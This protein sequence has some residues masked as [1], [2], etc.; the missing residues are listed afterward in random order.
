MNDRIESNFDFKN[1]DYLSIF[2]SR[3]ERLI[4]IRQNSD[5]LQSLKIYYKFNPAQFIIDWGCTADFAS[6]NK[7]QPA[8]IPFILFDKQNE[9]CNW[10]N[11]LW[12]NNQNGLV[13]KTRQMGMSWLSVALA[14]T[15]C[16]FNDDVK[17]GFGS[18]KEEY[19]DKRGDS[20]S[21]FEKAKIFIELIPKEF[22]GG[23][24]DRLH[25]KS[26]QIKFPNTNST[27]IGESGDNIGRGD[28]TSIYFVDEAAFLER[29]Y[30]AEASLAQGTRCRIDISTPNG[31]ANSFYEKRV[32]GKVPVFTFHWRDDPRKNDDWYNDQ[33]AKLDPVIVAQEIDINYN[34][35]VTGIVIPSLWIQSAIDAHKKLGIDISGMK[36][37]AL[38]VA[39]E[40]KDL[41]TFCGRYGILIQD[42]YEWSGKDS[43]IMYTT[44]QCIGHMDNNKYQQLIYDADGIGAGIRA[45]MRV[46]NESRYGY[47]QIDYTAFHGGSSVIQPTQMITD[48]FNNK[49]YFS[50]YKAQ[51]WWYLRLRFEKTH[52]AVYNNAEYDIDDIISI[53]SELLLLNKLVNELSSPTWSRNSSG[54]IIIDKRPEGIKSP[55]LADAVMMCY[56]PKNKLIV[57]D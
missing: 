50:N 1:P 51:S 4:K 16:L 3:V 25:R 34:A 31:L 46:A 55:N 57:Y 32:S 21:L 17:I 5:I 7:Y 26:M 6:A 48:K 11:D 18:R 22:T 53:S 37:A 36:Y 29:P 47:M 56:A 33:V 13:E 15:I 38:D 10:V 14:V 2:K 9:W 45:C 43:D 27:I 40:G 8:I 28:T 24:S 20:K 49:D 41:N 42:L 35:S 19:V 44:Q 54:K 30:I 52:Q 12:Q 23:W 39:D